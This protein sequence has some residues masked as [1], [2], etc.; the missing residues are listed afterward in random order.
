MVIRRLGG[1][2][3]DRVN[4]NVAVRG[5]PEACM[6]T[7][8][9][10]EAAVCEEMSRLEHEFM[11]RR[12]TDIHAYLIQDLVVVRLQG[13]LTDAEN[14]LV[15]GL[16]VGR[17]QELLKE[18]RTRLIETARPLM[19]AAIEE[20]IGVKVLSL[21]YDISMLTG[22]EIMVFTLANVAVLRDLKQRKRASKVT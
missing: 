9:E 8:G 4:N 19:E 20:I 22:D 7:R 15:K 2:L 10:I 13:V 14:Q 12:P 3:T 5:R 6:K 1:G 21:H 11:G 16:A 18:V 17:G